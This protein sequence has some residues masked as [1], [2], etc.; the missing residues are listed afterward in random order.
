MVSAGLVYWTTFGKLMFWGVFGPLDKIKLY[1]TFF[2]LPAK[3]CYNK[4]RKKQ[5]NKKAQCIQYCVRMY[6]AWYLSKDRCGKPT[7][8]LGRK[9]T[10]C[11]TN[12]PPPRLDKRFFL[13]C[14][15]WFPLWFEV[16]EESYTINAKVR[17]IRVLG[18]L[19]VIA[20]KYECLGPC[21]FALSLIFTA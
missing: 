18:H 6:S 1:C 21:W 20:V 5:T 2:Y 15:W 10:N 19:E 17:K 7:A 4:K 16:V 13:W 14:V 8:I 3:Y 9:K 12:Q 11:W